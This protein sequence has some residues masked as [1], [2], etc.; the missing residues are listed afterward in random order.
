MNGKILITGVGGSLEDVSYSLSALK[1]V[2]NSLLELGAET[3]LIDIKALNLPLFDYSGAKKQA[4]GD[5]KI[6]MDT[7]HSSQGFIF[8]SPEYHGTVSASFKNFIDHL[9][10]LS[11][12]DPPYL[13]LKPIGCISLGSG[14]NSGAS[15]LNT[16]MNIVHSLRGITVSTN[17]A[18]SDVKEVFDKNGEIID[19]SVKRRLK[20]LAGDIFFVSSRLT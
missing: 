11:S 18:I 19:D 12:Y 8:S 2:L 13:T 5:F 15:T 17:F 7:M 14:Y 10:Y 9:E 4:T 16:L 1:F 6:L 3:N 20:R